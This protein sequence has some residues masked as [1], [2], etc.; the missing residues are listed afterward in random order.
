MKPSIV[1]ALVLTLVLIAGCHLVTGLVENRGLFEMVYVERMAA[2]DSAVIDTPVTVT[3]WGNLPDPSWDFDHFELYFEM[4]SLTV[5]VFGKK[6]DVEAVAAQVLVPFE[7]DLSFTPEREG[8]L[9][10]RVIGKN[11]TL[12]TTLTVLPSKTDN[13]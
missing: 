6:S 10:I 5:G 9:T 13:P 3:V 4:R 2:P 8:I 12:M 1:F 11:D 7:K